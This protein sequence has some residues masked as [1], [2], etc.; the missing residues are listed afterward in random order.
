MIPPRI[1]NVKAL[2][3]FILELTYVSKETKH[4]DMKKT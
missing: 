3:N 2:D 1:Q 4:Y